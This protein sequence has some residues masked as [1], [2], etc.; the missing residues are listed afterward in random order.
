MP[1]KGSFKPFPIIRRIL[2]K[3]LYNEFIEK[4]KRTD[5]SWELFKKIINTRGEVKREMIIDDVEG[6]KHPLNDGLTVI[7]MYKP[8]KNKKPRNP[9]AAGLP[10]KPAVHNNLH[11]LGMVMRIRYLQIRMRRTR[12]EKLFVFKAGRELRRDASKACF[13]GKSYQPLP[14]RSETYV[15]DVLKLDTIIQKYEEKTNPL[16]EL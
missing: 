9:R 1:A 13:N 11:S 2:C 10:G 16:W 12:A 7:T 14:K 15:E 4:T 6:F 5:I 8:K 3:T